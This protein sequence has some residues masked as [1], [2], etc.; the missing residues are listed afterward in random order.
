VLKGAADKQ[1]ALRR[2]IERF[3]R[4]GNAAYH[5]IVIP[6]VAPRIA[7]LRELGDRLAAQR[8][9]LVVLVTPSKAVTMAKFLPTGVC[10]RPAA[11]E[12]RSTRFTALLRETGILVVDGPALVRAMKARDPLPPFARGSTHWSLLVGKRVASIMMDELGRS[13]RVDWGG[14]TLRDPEWTASPIGSD[15][16]LATLLN[17]WR[18]PLDYPTG[19]AEL[20]CRSTEAGRRAALIAVGG[21]FAVTVI[22]HLAACGL[23]DHL[24]LYFYY[25]ASRLRWPGD[26]ERV[27]RAGLRWQDLLD[28]PHV[29]LVEQNESLLGGAPHLDLFLDDALAALRSRHALSR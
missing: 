8:S 23:F 20:V 18:P 2:W 13:S 26:R 15:A 19:T 9:V 28:G 6:G 27:D 24:E 21:S 4:E 12:W 22:E 1:E 16:D 3:N 17:L 25:T 29:V 7:K 14:L 5:R 11:P 10:D